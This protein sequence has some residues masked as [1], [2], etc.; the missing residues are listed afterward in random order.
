[1]R[2]GSRVC[3]TGYLLLLYILEHVCNN[4]KQIVYKH[5]G[6]NAKNGLTDGN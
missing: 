3:E 6:E 2:K 5:E 4:E 1:M